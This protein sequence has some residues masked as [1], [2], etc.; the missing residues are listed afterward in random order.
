MRTGRYFITSRMDGF[1]NVDSGGA[2]MLARVVQPLVVKNI[3]D[4]FIQT[5][6][7]LGS[8]SKTAEVNVGGMQRL[9]GRLAHVQ[10]ETRQQLSRRWW[11]RWPNVRRPTRRPE[12]RAT[13]ARGQP[14]TGRST[15]Q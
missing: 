7:F 4:N 14:S 1:V 10:P 15:R 6:A 9:A 5:I 2:E 12:R 11:P 8:M 3:D 13:P